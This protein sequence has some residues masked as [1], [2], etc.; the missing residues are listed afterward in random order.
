MNWTETAESRMAELIATGK[1]YLADGLS[2]DIVLSMLK[3]E[4]TLSAKNWNKVIEGLNK[5][6]T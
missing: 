3:N 2:I 4:T 6:A 5:T 1:G